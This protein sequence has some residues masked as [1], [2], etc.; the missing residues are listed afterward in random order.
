M[1][2]CTNKNCKQVN[3]QSLDRFSKISSARGNGFNSWCKN[4]TCDANKK[5]YHA[6]PKKFIEQNKAVKA[7]NPDKYK[8]LRLRRKFNIS[9]AHYTF[10]LINQG[11]VCML[12]QQPETVRD[13]KSDKLKDLAV[14][15]CHTTKKVRGLLCQSCNMAFGLIK[16]NANTARRIYKYAKHHELNPEPI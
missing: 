16:E 5:R 14:D 3:P 4:C 13:S 9:L 6:N 10:L 2:T 7:R 8:D 11:H 12:C 1:K 15:H